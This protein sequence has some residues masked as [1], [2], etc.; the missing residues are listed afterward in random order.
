MQINKTISKYIIIHFNILGSISYLLVNKTG[1]NTNPCINPK[2]TIPN[3]I[4]KKI[5]KPSAWD[6]AVITIPKKVLMPETKL[7]DLLKYITI[8][9]Y[10]TFQN[11]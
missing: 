7:K 10:L 5:R 11:L 6:A 9:T 3:I 1:K 8:I 2:T 4:L